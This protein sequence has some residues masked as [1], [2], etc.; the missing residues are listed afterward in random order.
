MLDIQKFLVYLYTNILIKGLQCV[1][2]NLLLLVQEQELIVTPRTN[3]QQKNNT[4]L[5]LENL[6]SV[7]YILPLKTTFGVIIQQ[8]CNQKENIIKRFNV[9]LTFVYI[10]GLVL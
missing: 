7:K 8:M 4:N 1:Q 3:N 2:I 10:Y 6:K 9:L 5:L